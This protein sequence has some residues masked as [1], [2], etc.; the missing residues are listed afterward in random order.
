MEVNIY[1]NVF[2]QVEEELVMKDITVLTPTY[3]RE[4]NLYKLYNSLCVQTNKDFVWMIID[5]GSTDN[6]KEVVN[7]WRDENK[8]EIVYIYKENGGKHTALNIGI[9]NINTDMTFIVDSD[10]WL[11][12]N[13]IEIIY[14]YYNKY[15]DTDELC[16]F[17]FLRKFPNGEINNKSF[18]VNEKI[19][20]Y[21][22]SRVNGNIMGDK[23]EVFYTKC[24]KEF[25]FPE[26]PNEKFIS[27]AVIWIKMALKYKMVHINE[28]I[29]VGDYL[30]NGLT[31]NIKKNKI[32]APLGNIELAKV[33]MYKECCLKSRIKGMLFYI[34]YGNFAKFSFKKL[35]NDIDNKI[36]FILLYPVGKCIQIYWSRKYLK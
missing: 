1:K 34:I 24:L 18:P 25:P 31:K 19:E 11:V 2:K 4:K 32:K 9:K 30:S 17:S 6:T 33:L 5:D 12:D 27:E 35:L 29:Y 3:N 20:S 13:A 10:D 7:K 15:K 26:F 21:I 23:A 36:A 16:G 14:K 22:D 8:I 28:A